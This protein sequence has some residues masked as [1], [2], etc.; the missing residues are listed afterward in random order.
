[1][2]ASSLLEFTKNETMGKNLVANFI[3]EQFRGSVND[4]LSAALKGQETANF[5][6]PMFTKS[7]ERKDILLNATT[8]RGPDGEVTGVI[9]VGQD[10]SGEIVMYA[11]IALCSSV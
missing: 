2:Q 11:I 10:T 9:G 4:V 1:M 7:G 8:R 6:F 3:T 5:E